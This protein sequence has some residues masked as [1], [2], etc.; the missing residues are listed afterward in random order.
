[1]TKKITIRDIAREAGVSAATVSYILNDRKD[2]VISEATRKK[3]LQIVNLHG[4][5]VNFSAKCLSEGK[6]N[7][8]AL[9][10]GQHDFVLHSAEH[11]L[12]AD[13]LSAF[14]HTKGFSVRLVSNDTVGRL[15]NCDAIVCCDLSYSLFETIGD[16]NFCPLIA[17]NMCVD[18]HWLFYQINNDLSAVKKAADECF[19]E[20]YTTLCLK[21]NNTIL[22]AKIKEI[23]PNIVFVAGFEQLENLSGSL[24]VLGET[25]G[26]YC[27]RFAENIKIVDLCTPEKMEKLCQCIDIT[28]NRKDGIDHDIYI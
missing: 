17:Y 7:I 3:V 22:E 14:L 11:L 12:W 4:Y 18:N 2:Q 15:D 8:V 23:F 16:A 6:S 25:L 21:P 27:K 9:Y 13:K 28:V 1:M 5:K 20:G 26:N 19:E 24:V 10:L